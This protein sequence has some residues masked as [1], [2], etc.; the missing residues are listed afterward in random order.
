MKKFVIVISG[1]I[2][3]WIIILA[4]PYFFRFHDTIVDEPLPEILPS[5][6]F[7]DGDSAWE[8]LELSES[9]KATKTEIAEKISEAEAVK[10]TVEAEIAK[11]IAETEVANKA[12]EIET[13][14]KIVEAEVAK[15]I[16]EAEA[17]VAKKIAETEIAQ[18][19]AEAEVAKKIAETEIAQKVAEAEAEV[20]KKV[21]ESEVAESEVAE[22]E[23]AKKA[24]EAEVTYPVLLAKWDF[25]STDV[26]SSWVVKILDYWTKKILRIENLSTSSW[27]DLKV[28]FWVNSNLKTENDLHAGKFLVAHLKGNKWTQNYD[29]PADVDISKYKSVAIHCKRFNHSFAFANID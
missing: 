14:K 2:F 8:D 22:A 1:L 20:A 29:I 12:E 28:Y 15:K 16:A 5:E 17:G 9:K 6:V 23:V 24:A 3:V 19:V 11:K 7:I 18:K 4:F 13:A 26:Q 21:A 10:K 25:Y 27:P